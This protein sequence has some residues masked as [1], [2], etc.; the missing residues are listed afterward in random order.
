M[1][2]LYHAIYNGEIF[3]KSRCIW[4][5][6]AL[7]DF[8][9]SQLTSLGYV[10]CSDNNKTWQ[11]GQKKVVVCLVDDIFTCSVDKSKHLSQAFDSDTVVI[12]D[13]FI[14]CPTQYQVLRLPDSFFG[15]YNHTP[16]ATTS[17]PDRR[18]GLS[19]NRIDSARLL[20]LLEITKRSPEYPS[21]GTLDYINFNCWSWDGRNDSDGEL[22]LNFDREFQKLAPELQYLYADAYQILRSKMPLKNYNFDVDQMHVS[23]RLNIVMET[24]GSD[25]NIALSEKLFRT[26]CLPVP[27]MV[28][29][30]RHTVVYLE[31]LGFDVLRDVVAHEY[32]H[33][34]AGPITGQF[35][36][37]MVDFVY[38]GSQTIDR[39]THSTIMRAAQAAR[40]NQ[41][42]LSE[43]QASWP[44]DFA[45]WLPGVIE[46]IK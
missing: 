18:F 35:G 16:T 41:Q 4:H 2:D 14:N 32:D 27:W 29:S 20:M 26:L 36:D 28:Y 45:N 6:N 9:R 33:A 38:E 30:G 24:Y 39:M 17:K 11:R 10:S 31:K 42:R 21:V 44:T 37:K 1:T 3:Q 8:F 5:E 25:N 7:M 40:L 43:M 12:T 13:N 22:Q 15:I 23:S 46:K 19:V 34:P